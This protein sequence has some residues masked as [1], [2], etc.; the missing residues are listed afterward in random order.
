MS[1][2]DLLNKATPGPWEVRL[3]HYPYS[4]GVVGKQEIC[5]LADDQETDARLIALAPDMARLLIDM[6]TALEDWMSDFAAED[7]GD[8]NALLAQFA[9]LNTK[10]GETT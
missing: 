2:A 5:G 10:A 3:A 1:L 7:P 8:T 9:A 6:S 4:F